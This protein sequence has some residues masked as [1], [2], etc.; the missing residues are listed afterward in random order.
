METTLTERYQTRRNWLKQQIIGGAALIGSGG[1][2]PD[3]NL[4]DKNLRYLTG[5]DS[6]NAYLLLAPHGIMVERAETLSGPEQGRGRQV[7]EILFVEEMSERDAFMDGA[8]PTLESLRE[9]SGVDRVMPL[10]K[11]EGVI[12]SLLDTTEMLYFSTAGITRLSEALTPEL[13]LINRIRER[14]YWVNL[15]NCATMIHQMRGVKDEYEVACLR[16][17]FEIQTSIFEKIMQALKSGENES[18]GEA[19]F[20]YET[21][22]RAAEGVGGGMADEKYTCSVIIGSGK[23]SMIPHYHANNQVIQDGDLVLIDSGITVD[24]YSSD[25]TR[26]FPAN[27]KFSP[28]QRELYEIVLEAELAAIETMK[29]GSTMLEAHQAAYNVFKRYDLDKFGYG[30]CGHP[31]G[32]SIHDPNGCSMDDREQPFEPG[33]VVVIE[34]F[35]MLSEEGMGIRIEDGVLITESGHEVLAGPPKDADAVEALCKRE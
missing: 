17:A 22:I 9:M 2:A 35:L 11:M 29:P 18:L 4:Y 15:R 28:R 1:V 21:R 33:V 23:N 24:G 32:L 25:I 30:N 8:G 34:P 12:E 7:Q 26:T 20:D 3:R 5:V 27:G 19:I 16:K 13:E 6:K 31:V 14:F 10:T